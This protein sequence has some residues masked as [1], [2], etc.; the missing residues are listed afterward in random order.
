MK[1]HKTVTSLVLLLICIGVGA[2]AKPVSSI[3]TAQIV[4]SSVYWGDSS[5][6]PVNARP[7]DVNAPLSIVIANGGDDVARGVTAR[8]DLTT[9]FS[10]DYYQD[11][12]KRSS[13]SVS[14]TAGDIQAGQSQRLRFVLSIA[15]NATEG[16]YR[17]SLQL[18]YSSARE[19]QQVV[20]TQS[21][22]VP[23]WR[24]KLSIQRV[25]TVP[26]KIYPGSVGVLLRV[27]IVN[28]GQGAEQDV[29]LRL[30]LENPFKASSSSSDK[31]FLGTVPSYQVSLAEFHFDVD[32]AA[33]YGDYSLRLLYTTGIGVPSL[34]GRVNLYL[35]QKVRFQIT[36]VNPEQVSPGD[37]G[38][39]FSFSVKNTGS[40]AAKS[41]RVQ[42]RPGNY[43]S[44]TLTDFL[45]TLESGEQ[46]TAFATLDVD[47]K[48][49]EGDQRID[50]RVDWT[51]DENSLYDT[52][53]V[54]LKVRRQPFFIQYAPQLSLL[55]IAIALF[56]Y[57]RRRKQKPPA[58]SS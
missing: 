7:G 13:S 31:I 24:G 21:V 41:V 29:E 58:K 5:T 35:E 27:W 3:G 57:Y 39:T 6:A 10:F 51:Q 9:P 54:V 37:V 33:K 49:P 4:V 36:S 43:F 23:V 25:T 12:V 28:T 11:G 46:K 22:D 47:G 18:S 55:V 34:T 52:I 32:D 50:L 19:L 42:L 2:W 45:G 56:M 8:L 53:A 20:V 26:E 40:V 14:I 48:A 16:I 17:L 30:T 15:S 38:V 44:G 1:L